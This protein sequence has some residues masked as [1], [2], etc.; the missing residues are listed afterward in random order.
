MCLQSL[1]SVRDPTFGLHICL[2]SWLTDSPSDLHLY[3]GLNLLTGACP[4]ICD[5]IHI[6]TNISSVYILQI[7]Q[8]D[9]KK[10]MFIILRADD[11]K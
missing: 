2:R 7:C 8:Y 11:V 4:V 9:G 1:Q 10:L 6:I 3:P 5:G